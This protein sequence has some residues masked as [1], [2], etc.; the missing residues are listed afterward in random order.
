MSVAQ[1]GIGSRIT[2]TKYGKGVIIGIHAMTYTVMFIDEGEVDL[3]KNDQEI[4][5]IEKIDPDEDGV[6][7]WDV[8]Q[9]LMRIL[10]KWSDITELVAIA[11]RWKGG[12]MVLQPKDKTLQAKE[13]PIEQF[14]HKIVMLRDRL[15][16]M[17]Q[18]INA[19]KGLDDAEKVDLQQYIT[20]I[21]GTLTTFN[22][23][24]KHKED[25]FVGESTK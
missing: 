23:L 25:Q 17:E 21:Y 13:V 5:I 18:K 12:N 9:M 3:A 8:E 15:R 6:S 19:S 16:V 11:D 20:R 14:F 4:K 1:L 7:L 24:F 22:V 2:H 10:R